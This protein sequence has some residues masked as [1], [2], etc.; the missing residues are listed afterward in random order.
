MIRRPPRSTRTDTLF[1]YTT[2]FRSPGVRSRWRPP[3]GAIP[4]WS[5]HLPPLRGKR[6]LRGNQLVDRLAHVP[7]TLQV[8]G[9]LL[10]ELLEPPPALR[11]RRFRIRLRDWRS[12]GQVV[13]HEQ[14]KRLDP[15]RTV[16]RPTVT[17]TRSPVPP[18]RPPGP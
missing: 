1:P 16:E 4:N 5:R 6:V 7:P 10:D 18:P 9:E 15:T 12:L 17:L 3:A 13:A 8:P 2:L 11:P 14:H